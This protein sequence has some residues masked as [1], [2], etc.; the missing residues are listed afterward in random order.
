MKGV[1]P[2]LLYCTMRDGLHDDGYPVIDIECRFD[3]GQKFAAVEVDGEFPDLARL[4]HDCLNRL[5]KPRTG[6]E[7]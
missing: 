7:V 5:A 4:I 6:E 3:D 1:E 2:R